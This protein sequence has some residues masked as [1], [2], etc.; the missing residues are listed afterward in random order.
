MEPVRCPGA[1]TRIAEQRGVFRA[2]GVSGM[3]F[4]VAARI[5]DLL[6]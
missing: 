4:T 2:A 6:G 5:D 3:A 1:L